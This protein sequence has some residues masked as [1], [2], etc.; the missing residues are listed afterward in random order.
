[1][2]AM[3]L[4]ASASMTRSNS[5]FPQPLRRQRCAARQLR[6]RPPGRRRRREHFFNLRDELGRFKELRIETTR[7]INTSVTPFVR[8]TRVRAG[9]FVHA[10]LSRPNPLEPSASGFSPIRDVDTAPR[11]TARADDPRGATM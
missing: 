10:R 1:M 4:S 6:R 9:S 5:V 3:R 8:F 7:K 11:A 2:M